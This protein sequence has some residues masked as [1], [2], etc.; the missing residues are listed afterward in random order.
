MGM[1]EQLPIFAQSAVPVF[2]IMP[3]NI[4]LDR[5]NYVAF[6]YLISLIVLLRNKC[7]TVTENIGKLL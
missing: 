5:D 3:L 6:E 7:L 4:L 1:L 2:C